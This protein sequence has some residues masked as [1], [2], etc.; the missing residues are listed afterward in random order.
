MQ[1][2]ITLKNLD[3]FPI[4]KDYL[5]VFIDGERESNIILNPDPV[6]P[7]SLSQ[8]IINTEKFYVSGTLHK[9]RVAGP[10]NTEESSV[11]C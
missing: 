3:K 1:I 9:V 4:L 7:N 8:L 11:Y 10:T 2:M 5:I 6:A